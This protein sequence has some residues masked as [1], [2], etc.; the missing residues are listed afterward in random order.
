MVSA[1]PAPA[2]A[3]LLQRRIMNG[4]HVV[5]RRNHGRR[6]IWFSWIQRRANRQ[7]RQILDEKVQ[8]CSAFHGEAAASKNPNRT[9]H[10]ERT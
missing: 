8:C 4:D 3:G 10:P 9:S 5:E 6:A 1:D 7:T 2:W